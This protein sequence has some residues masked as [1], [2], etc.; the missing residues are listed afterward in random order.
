MKE[1]CRINGFH[2]FSA[3]ALTIAAFSFCAHAQATPFAD[4]HLPGGGTITAL[5]RLEGDSP[6][7]LAG[8]ANGRVFRSADGAKSWQPTL[9][10][11]QSE[12]RAFMD[13]GGGVVLAGAGLVFDG[14]IDCFSSYCTDPYAPGGIFRSRDGGLTWAKVADS[15]TTAFSSHAGRIFAARPYGVSYS[16]DSGVSWH[17]LA[18][19][20]G[21]PN[22]API[23]NVRG[24]A[25]QGDTLILMKRLYGSAIARWNGERLTLLTQAGHPSPQFIFSSPPWLYAT[26][27]GSDATDFALSR[28]RDGGATW[29]T[30]SDFVPYLMVR[31][32][33]GLIAAAD[34]G[35]FR[36]ADG[37]SWTK[38]ASLTR[39]QA[40]KVDALVVSGDTLFAGGAGYGGVGIHEPGPGPWRDSNAGMHDWATED[41]KYWNGALYAADGQG[42]LVSLEKGRSEW[43]T[44]IGAGN[45]NQLQ[46][47]QGGLFAIISRSVIRLDP[48][49]AVGTPSDIAIGNAVDTGTG[50]FGAFDDSKHILSVC[51]GGD[52]PACEPAAM[53]GFQ[54][55]PFY[56]IMTLRSLHP[57]RAFAISGDSVLVALDSLW[58]SSDRGAH[59]SRAGLP[60]VQAAFL[61]AWNGAFWMGGHDS[62]FRREPGGQ[63]WQAVALRGCRGSLSALAFRPGGDAILAGDSG[64]F[65]RKNGDSTWSDI[66]EGLADRAVRSLA[67][68]GN[69]LAVSLE[70]GGVWTR[71]LS[72]VV[73]IRGNARAAGRA[74]TYPARYGAWNIGGGAWRRIDGKALAK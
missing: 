51:H 74:A 47:W 3:S 34:S 44:R 67:V 70:N 50:W 32:S 43:S 7:L 9:Q 26:R 12:V 36:S 16:A 59:W 19:E 66:S 52:V 1:L 40:P 69:E 38:M 6:A 24:M 35:F 8:T 63:A 61:K 42:G 45:A 54:S 28:T 39:S 27:I 11:A 5:A 56:D 30:L 72:P 2:A 33:L 25:W 73:S 18:L 41:V 21:S 48:N 15:A 20:P 53:A 57:F 31:D 22:P 60:P 13:L 58:L 71:T 55:P 65:Y 49:G 23:S 62:L 4:R 10:N 68:D 14:V 17:A 37:R 64:V 46:N 29:E